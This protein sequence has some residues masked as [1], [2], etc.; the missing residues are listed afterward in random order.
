MI[1]KHEFVNDIPDMLEDGIIY[2]SLQ[3]A[4]IIHKCICGCGNEVVTPLSPTDWRFSYD[5]ETVTLDPSIGNWN[6]DCQS[7]Y[8]IVNNEV[9]LARSWSYAEIEAGRMRDRLRKRKYFISRDEYQATVNETKQPSLE[10]KASVLER[11]IN[12]IR[13]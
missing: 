9:R 11:I 1:L 2:I 5:G 12:W 4:T 7:H 6:F 8:W 3:Y 13:G 10:R